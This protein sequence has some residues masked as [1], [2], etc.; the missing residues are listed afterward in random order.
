MVLV[1]QG[2]LVLVVGLVDF[3]GGWLL[4]RV[5]VLVGPEELV[6]VEGS[7]DF[8]LVGEQAIL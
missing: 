6:H 7:V 4:Q 1:V 2:V 3:L 5:T 8:L